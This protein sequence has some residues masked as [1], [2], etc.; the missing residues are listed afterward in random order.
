MSEDVQTTSPQKLKSLIEALDLM[1]DEDEWVPTDKQWKRI[2]QMIETLDERPAAPA[3]LNPATPTRVSDVPAGSTRVTTVGPN[4][5][6]VGAIQFP[7]VPVGDAPTLP[8]G[9]GQPSALSPNVANPG[10][11][12]VPSGDGEVPANPPRSPGL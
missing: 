12:Q 6:T 3:P 9:A 2:K 5:A 8:D 10:A 4:P 1:H 11:A 7:V